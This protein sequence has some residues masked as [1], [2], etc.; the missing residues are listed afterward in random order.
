MVGAACYKDV[1]NDGYLNFSCNIFFSLP[2]TCVIDWFP[3]VLAC[4]SLF[5]IFFGLSQRDRDLCGR[6][7]YEGVPRWTTGSWPGS[8]CYRTLWRSWTSLIAPALRQAAWLLSGISGVYP[9]AQHSLV[10]LTETLMWFSWLFCGV[11]ALQRT[12]A[13]GCVIPPWHLK[14]WFGH[15]PA[16]GDVTTMPDHRYRLRPQPEAGDR[17]GERGAG[18]GVGGIKGPVS[19]G[20]S[21]LRQL[22]FQNRTER[23]PMAE[24]HTLEKCIIWRQRGKIIFNVRPSRFGCHGVQ[25]LDS[26]WSLGTCDS[27]LTSFDYTWQS[28]SQIHVIPGGLCCFPF[29]P[30]YCKDCPL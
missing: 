12:P 29:T 23:A 8:M 16:G 18:R 4:K 25:L 22:C 21:P 2:G 15:Y 9:N 28:S 7:H 30:A 26:D 5:L 13:S 17:R 11:F 14:S 3:F 1:Q 19:E 10:I 20:E 27:T 24:R 6:C